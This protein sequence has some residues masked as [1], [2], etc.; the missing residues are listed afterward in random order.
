M[1]VVGAG[2][3][4]STAYTPGFGLAT[5]ELHGQRH[6]SMTKYLSLQVPVF[7]SFRSFFRDE[8]TFFVCSELNAPLLLPMSMSV[9]AN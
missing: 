1:Q 5:G 4:Q 2:S 9:A 3:V 8:T 6:L 7:C